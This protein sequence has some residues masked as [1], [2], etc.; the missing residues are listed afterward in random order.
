DLIAQLP[1]EQAIAA[2]DDVPVRPLLDPILGPILSLAGVPGLLNLDLSDAVR[3]LVP[4]PGTALLSASLLEARAGVACAAGVPSLAG[5]STLTGVRLLGNDVGVDGVVSQ[6]L[7]V[8]Q[9]G[10]IDPASLN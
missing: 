7:T 1:T 9:G 10:T 2:L 5:S 3:A 8:M 6:A 4:A